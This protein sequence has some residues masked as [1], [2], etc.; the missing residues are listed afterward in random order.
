MREK[1]V[2]RVVPGVSNG[3]GCGVCVK[4]WRPAQRHERVEGSRLLG[5]R[6]SASDLVFR[7]ECRGV[8]STASFLLFP[9]APPAPPGHA[10]AAES[11]DLRLGAQSRAEHPYKPYLNLKKPQ[12]VT[13]DKP[14][15]VGSLRDLIP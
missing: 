2:E 10:A 13:N 15:K 1:N 5:G 9:A 14:G 8:S 12:K 3:I 11:T 7:N 6:E 4:S